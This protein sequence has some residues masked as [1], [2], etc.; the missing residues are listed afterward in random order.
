MGKATYIP[1][2]DMDR[3]LVAC[4]ADVSEEVLRPL[5]MAPE[6]HRVP[7]HLQLSLIHI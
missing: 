6:L 7:E 3:L 1:R 4:E 2:T 5:H